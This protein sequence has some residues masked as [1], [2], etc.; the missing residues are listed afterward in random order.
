MWARLSLIL[1]AALMAALAACTAPFAGPTPTSTAPPSATTTAPPSASVVPASPDLPADWIFVCGGTDI[2]HQLDT[3][4]IA[5]N[6]TFIGSGHFAIDPAYTWDLRGMVSADEVSW[7]LTYTGAE[8][9]FVYSGSGS[10][11]ADGALEST[12]SPNVNGC[13][14]VTT[15]A[16]VF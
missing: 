15:S 16:G 11:A 14:V 4:V 10:V 7:S 6:G 8:A 9:G 3:L 12:V 2:P 13:T 5:A 1:V